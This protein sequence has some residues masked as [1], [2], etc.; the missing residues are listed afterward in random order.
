[1]VSMESSICFIEHNNKKDNLKKGSVI[2]VVDCHID[3]RFIFSD[4]NVSSN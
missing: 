4:S 3:K 2:I 1:M